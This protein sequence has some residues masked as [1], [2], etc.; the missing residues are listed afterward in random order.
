[1]RKIA[2]WYD[3]Q[4][5]YRDDVPQNVSLEGLVSRSK[6]ISEVLSLIESTGKVH[7]TLEGRKIIVTK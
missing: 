5:I 1:M 3:V 7:F 4:V 6:S 2:R